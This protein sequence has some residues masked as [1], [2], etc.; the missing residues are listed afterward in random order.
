MAPP[1]PNQ[2]PPKSNGR[3][4][5]RAKRCPHFVP[6]QSKR[7]KAPDWTLLL[8]LTFFSTLQLDSPSTRDFMGSPTMVNFSWYLEG[9]G[10]PGKPT[11]AT[12]TQTQN[13]Q[14]RCLSDLE[15]VIVAA[16]CYKGGRCALPMLRRG[17]Q[18]EP[19]IKAGIYQFT[20][21]PL[22]V[23]ALFEKKRTNFESSCTRVV[24]T[25]LRVDHIVVLPNVAHWRSFNDSESVKKE[26]AL[27]SIWVHVLFFN[28][29]QLFLLL[30]AFW[31]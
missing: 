12:K 2:V 23:E 27:D 1:K 15:Q 6:V 3:L 31:N 28:L 7:A 21:E 19:S 16:P 8:A 4:Q 25:L 29:G 18:C 24:V 20:Q 14:M 22:S 10:K 9:L 13:R 5:M 11:N 17:Q 30:A 26:P